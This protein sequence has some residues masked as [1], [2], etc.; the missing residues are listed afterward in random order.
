MR[1]V[2]AVALLTMLL[3]AAACG[4][5]D[6][7]TPTPTPRPTLPLITPTFP[8]TN[9]PTPTPPFGCGG[10]EWEQCEKQ[11]ESAASLDF[12]SRYH[13]APNSVAVWSQY[14]EWPDS[15]LGVYQQ[16]IA[17]AQVVTPGFRSYLQGADT[18]YAEYHT[19]LMGHAVFAGESNSPPP[20]ASP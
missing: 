3:S 15:C 8:P 6:G 18:P 4:S 19:D 5:G 1:W 16:G 13:P 11:A 9:S 17:C 10:G 20:S 2:V 14:V 12:S 7:A